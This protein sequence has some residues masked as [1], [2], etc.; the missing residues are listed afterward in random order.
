[1]V[2]CF[3]CYNLSFS[4]GG[5]TMWTTNQCFDLF[6]VTGC[7]SSQCMYKS[8][9]ISRIPNYYKLFVYITRYLTRSRCIDSVLV[10]SEQHVL[11]M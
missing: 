4:G 3:K 1:M 10:L 8:T 9:C 6:H 7:I 11:E 5:T 2:F